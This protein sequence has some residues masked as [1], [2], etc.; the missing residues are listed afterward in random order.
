MSEVKYK[1]IKLNQVNFTHVDF[2]KTPLKGVDLSDCTIDGILVSDTYAE[3]RGAKI[4]MFQAAELARL[5][6]VQIV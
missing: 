3:L 6:G 5:L 4:N 1:G 2:F